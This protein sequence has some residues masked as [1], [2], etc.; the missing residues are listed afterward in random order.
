MDKRV[1]HKVLLSRSLF[2]L[3]KE[4]AKAMG[5]PRLS[6]ACNVAQDAVECFLLAICDA[7]GIDLGSNAA[8]DKYIEKINEKISP[9]ILPFS[10]QLRSLNKL[11]VNSKHYGLEPSAVELQQ[12][13]LVAEEFFREASSSLLNSD[14]FT[15][16]FSEI[17]SSGNERDLMIEAESAYRQAD[18]RGCLIACRKALFHAIESDY[19]AKRFSSGNQLGLLFYF[20][21]VPQFARSRDWIEKNVKIPTDY[22]VIDHQRV[23]MTLMKAGVTPMLYW[24]VCRLTP[25]VYKSFGE[26]DWVV[27]NEFRKLTSSSIR[28]NAEYVLAATLELLIALDADNRRAKWIDNQEFEIPLVADRVPILETAER[29]AKVAATSPPGVTK[30]R[31]DFSTEGLDKSGHYW[32]VQHFEG[33][34]MSGFVHGDF[35]APLDDTR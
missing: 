22:I 2:Q 16:G 11:R 34:L 23:E 5:G 24:N 31:C 13:V 17:L 7:V 19:D 28:D 25:D 12:L 14:Y 32:H 8:F 15:V 4:N 1:I 9:S 20:S 29:T 27:K 18:F 10:A 33:Q 21:K 35:V 30:L 6:I 26:N 3:A